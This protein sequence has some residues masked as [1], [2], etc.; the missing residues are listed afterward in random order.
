[1]NIL[2]IDSSP[3]EFGSV[4]RELTAD[5]VS[6]WKKRYPFG[7]VTY[8]DVGANPP[9]HLSAE[10]MNALH[11]GNR[12]VLSEA[13]QKEF[14]TI[15]RAVDELINC[16]ALVIGAPMYNYSVSSNLKA[17]LDQ[18]SQAGRTFRHTAGG[19]V[20]LVPDK[21]VYLVSSRG[22]VYSRGEGRLHDFQEPYLLSILGFLGLTD[23]TIIRAEGVSLSPAAKNAAM[24]KARQLIGTLFR[25]ETALY[26]SV[27]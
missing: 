21:P 27:A 26:A 3:F 8:R 5:V 23:V 24:A 22:G 12:G 14:A 17:W 10:V 20:G 13:G 7:T 25:A 4:S 2:H 18:I 16:D 11:N 19:P 1:M 15:N 6:A 9:A